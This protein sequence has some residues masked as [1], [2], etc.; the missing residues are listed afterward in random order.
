M[1]MLYG[2]IFLAGFLFLF[3]QVI[4][5]STLESK[6][7]P[8]Y[9][10]L[11]KEHGQIEYYQFGKGSPIVLIPGYAMDVSG[12]SLDFLTALAEHHQL[13]VLNNRNVG[14]SKVQSSDYSSAALADD[15][16]ELIQYLHLKNPTVLGISM[17][18]MIAQQVAIRH[19]MQVGH[20]VLIN[21]AISGSKSV[22]PN[23][24][25]ENKMLSFPHHMIGIYFVALDYFFPPSA[26]PKMAYKLIVDRFQPKKYQPIQ[27]GIMLPQ[28]RQLLMEWIQD[29]D[30]ALKLSKIPMPVLI[31]NGEADIIIPPVNSEILEKTI[32]K[33]KLVRWKEGGHAMIFQYPF[34]IAKCIDENI[35]LSLQPRP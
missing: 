30:A 14:G 1:K 22:H 4:N 3:N 16:A 9:T 7:S 34:E 25:V 24:K 26:K 28:Q 11:T 10:P 35:V 6:L 19:P 23:P 21:T 13:I 15:V 31:L 5:A 20:L 27:L 18:G 17:G 2:I 32:P 12:W 33:A 29:E 8:Q